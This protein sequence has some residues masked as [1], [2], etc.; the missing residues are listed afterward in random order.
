MAWGDAKHA[1]LVVL[2]TAAAI[3]VFDWLG[4]LTTDVLLI[5]ALLV[6]IERRKLL[7]AAAYSIGL[8]GFTYVLFVYVLKTPLEARPIRILGSPLGNHPA[9]PLSRLFRRAS[10]RTTRGTRFS[11]AW[12]ARWSA[13]CPASVRSPAFLFCCR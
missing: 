11:A 4:F 2:L 12:S 8:V 9:Q 13:C 7:P 5:F 6:I 3:A 10:S 1:G